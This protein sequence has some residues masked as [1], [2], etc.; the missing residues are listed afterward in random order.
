L[1]SFGAKIFNANFDAVE[2]CTLVMKHPLAES[3]R[4]FLALLP[5]TITVFN[6]TSYLDTVKKFSK[7]VFRDETAIDACGVTF[8][9]LSTFT[10][11]YTDIK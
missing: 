10:F 7:S 5:L 8:A 2:A 4:Y 11:I 9:H 1:Q 6:S 3:F